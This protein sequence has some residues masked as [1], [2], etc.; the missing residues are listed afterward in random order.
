MKDRELSGDF[1]TGTVEEIIERLE[2][3]FPYEERK[4]VAIVTK[5]TNSGGI[6]IEAKAVEV[7]K[8]VVKY[9][10][11]SMAYFLTD[12]KEGFETVKF[13]RPADELPEVSKM[14]KEFISWGLGTMIDTLGRG[15]ILDY[16]FASVQT[17]LSPVNAI[18]ST[19]DY[20]LKELSKADEK[21][22]KVKEELEETQMKL[23]QY[24]EFD[25]CKNEV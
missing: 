13:R 21:L 20:T 3:T 6:S 10:E 23:D 22:D 1:F 12:D 16:Y 11:D 25:P 4:D 18:L 9:V 5:P 7:S 24:E 2:T 19:L 15:Y 8:P 17:M 14:R